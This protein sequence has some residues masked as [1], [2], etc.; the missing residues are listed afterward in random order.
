MNIPFRLTIISLDTDFSEPH[1]R[2][3]FDV[4]LVRSTFLTIAKQR[5]R[6]ER[7]IATGAVWKVEKTVG[8]GTPLWEITG[9]LVGAKP[10]GETSWGLSG[11]MEVHYSVRM[12]FNAVGSLPKY[13]CE[14]YVQ[15][16]TDEATDEFDLDEARERPALGLINQQVGTHPPP[17]FRA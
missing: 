11:F 9:S 13:S 16:V 8:D 3:A 14:E 5:V 10:G 4:R 2:S 1:I 12:T 15:M 17:Y 6:I 7:I